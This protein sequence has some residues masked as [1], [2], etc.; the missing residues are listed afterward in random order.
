MARNPRR[1]ITRNAIEL[2]VGR[3]G[4]VAGAPDLRPHAFRHFFS[5]YH[6]VRADTPLTVLQTMM[7]HGS[8]RT[9]ERYLRADERNDA[10]SSCNGEV[11]ARSEQ[12]EAGW[13]TPPNCVR[14]PNAG[15]DRRA[16]AQDVTASQPKGR[17]C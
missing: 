5:T 7:S 3:L 1:R 6:A 14:P 17:F 16:R 8:R 12:S 15:A 4:E 10:A 2:R 13:S 9:T 11:A